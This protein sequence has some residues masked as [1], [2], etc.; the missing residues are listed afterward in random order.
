[1]FYIQ[2]ATCLCHDPQ[3]V[4]QKQVYCTNINKISPTTLSEM[5]VPKS[6]THIQY[7]PFCNEHKAVSLND[8]VGCVLAG[9]QISIAM[10]V[11]CMEVAVMM[12]T[13]DKQ[14]AMQRE[15]RCVCNIN[16]INRAENVH[17]S[18]LPAIRQAG[19][20]TIALHE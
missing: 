10:C 15:K 9:L 12:K 3:S 18:Q 20:F 14:L 11:S 4:R 8:E 17:Q 6:T 7:I 19:I 5:E 13:T 2:L 1:M 16:G